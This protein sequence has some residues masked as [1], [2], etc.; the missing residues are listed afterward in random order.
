MENAT[1]ALLIA[2]GIF[3]AIVILTVGILLFVNYRDIVERY[4]ETVTMQ[5]IAEINKH[6]EKYSGRNNITI[7]EVVTAARIANKYNNDYKKTV[8]T[9]KIGNNVITGME[10]D[11]YIDL[12]QKKI[13]F[14][15]SVNYNINASSNSDITYHN[16]EED[17]YEGMVEV[18]KFTP[19]DG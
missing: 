6:F 13:E 9:V 14:R 12:L 18:I 15:Y 3:L 17:I 16:G 2:G 19:E 5:T 10:N 11:D 4:D 7:Q 1:Q 8:I